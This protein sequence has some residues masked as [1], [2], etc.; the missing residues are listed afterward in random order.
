MKGQL[1]YALGLCRVSL[2][3]THAY[4][5]LSLA[6][7]CLQ[8]PCR[9]DLAGP[10]VLSP[11][12]DVVQDQDLVW[13]G[14]QGRPEEGGPR[15]RESCQHSRIAVPWETCDTELEPDAHRH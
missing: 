2:A 10:L 12:K 11:Q 5:N 6:C 14:H 9:C 7:I 1:K 3:C 15:Q 8:S 4:G 13:Q